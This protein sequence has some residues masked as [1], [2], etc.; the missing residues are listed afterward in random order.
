MSVAPVEKISED[1]SVECLQALF[2]LD[3]QAS[4]KHC[5]KTRQGFGPGLFLVFFD[6]VQRYM[7]FGKPIF[8]TQ[9]ISFL[10]VQNIFCHTNR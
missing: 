7:V 2:F 3:W 8:S 5:I 6:E 1:I 4:R 9:I 10:N